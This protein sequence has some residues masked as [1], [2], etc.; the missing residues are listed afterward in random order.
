MPRVVW[1]LHR[2]R[3][4]VEVVLIQVQDGQ[5]YPLTLLADTGAGAQKVPF[6]L[7]LDEH[8]CIQCG[9]NPGTSMVLGGAYSG[10]YPVYDLPI[11]IPA[12]GF[13]Q[14]VRAV[15]VPWVPS[16][17]DGIACF[18]FLNRFTYGNFG[19]PAQFGLEC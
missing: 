13:V 17:F 1:Q 6:H 7:I 8:D 12:L 2:G 16:G 3:P 15:G 9:G 5:S 4:R 18:G 19:D 11:Q 10:S 14:N